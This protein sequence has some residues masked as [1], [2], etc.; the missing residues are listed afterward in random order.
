VNTTGM[1]LNWA[2]FRRQ[3]GRNF[4]TDLATL[5]QFEV[6]RWP[7]A[8]N[9]AGYR[10]RRPK[11]TSVHLI[12]TASFLFS[13]I[14]HS[15]TSCSEA[16]CVVYQVSVSQTDP[17]NAFYTTLSVLRSS[18]FIASICCGFVGRLQLFAQQIDNKWK[19]GVLAYT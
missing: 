2:S 1:L 9:T 10:L 6:V 17:R 13:L 8:G 5:P 19:C 14:T 3:L 18:D 4:H 7:S 15:I 16:T 11:I 12:S